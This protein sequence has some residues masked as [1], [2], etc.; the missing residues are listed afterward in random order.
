MNDRNEKIVPPDLVY[1]T[2]IRSTPQKVWDA[3]TQSAF[4]KQFFFGRTIESDWMQ[5]S[6][7]RLVMEDGRTDV[8]GE[9]L[10]SDPPRRLKLSWKVDWIEEARALEPAIVSYDIEQAGDAVKLT[11]TQHNPGPVPRKFVEAGKQGWAAIL[12]S[13]KSLLETGEAL[14]IKMGAPQ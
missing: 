11:L 6:P 2:F 3:L 12:S 10:D 14:V 9:V 8:E 7:W 13:L 5:G 1:V 4:T